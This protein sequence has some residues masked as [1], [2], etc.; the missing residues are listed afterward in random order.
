LR[1]QRSE[2]ALQESE[3][4]AILSRTL[5]EVHPAP[6]MLGEVIVDLLS[7]LTSAVEKLETDPNAA[8]KEADICNTISFAVLNASNAL[9]NAG[10]LGFDALLKKHGAEAGGVDG[11]G[12]WDKGLLQ[13]INVTVQ[14][15]TARAEATSKSSEPVSV[16]ESSD[17][18]P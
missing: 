1:N 8:R 6:A 3:A 18:P 2:K 4:N 14:G 12:K 9:K 13:Q 7:K 17:A 10:I 5:R 16:S 15:M 11:H